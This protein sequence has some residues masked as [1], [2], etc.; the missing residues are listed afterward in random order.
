M[1]GPAPA[2]LIEGLLEAVWVVDALTLRIVAVN[3]AAA[4]LIGTPADNLLGRAVV[5]L[6][7]TPQDQFFW[8]DVAAGL[9]SGIHSETLVRA[10]DGVPVPVERRVSRTLLADGQLAYLVAFRDL[11]P[12]QR[13]EK[14]LEKIVAEL[15][16]TLEST[17]DGILV[18]DMDGTVR[19]YN[20][21]FAELWEVPEELLIKPQDKALYAHVANSA[22]DGQVYAQQLQ[23]IADEPLLQF[24]DVVTLRSGRML[25]RVTMPQFCRGEPTGRVFSYRD[26]TQRVDFETRLRLAAKVF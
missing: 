10:A 22:A 17:A 18:A 26:I 25:E 19:S 3:A 12:Q 24:S 7:A 14:E 4:G 5:E 11:R 8:E 2:P 20:R 21:H 16:A 9:E 23:R 15:R 13:A 6:S 1:N